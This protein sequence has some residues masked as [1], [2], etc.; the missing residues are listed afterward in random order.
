MDWLRKLAKIDRRIIFLVVF[1]AISIPIFF[2]LNL[3]VFITKEV[4]GV[5]DE[6]DQLPPGSAVMLVFDYEPAATPECDPMATALL[7]HCFSRNLRVIGTTLYTSGSGIAERL[8]TQ[9]GKEYGKVRGKDYVHL[10][11]KSGVFAVVIGLGENLKETFPKDYYGDSTDSLTALHDIHS[12][13]DIPYLVV[14]HDDATVFTWIIYGYER[15][16]IKIGTGCTAVMAPGNYP[17]LQ[18]KQITGI[19]GGLKGA[20]E[21]E[22]LVGYRGSGAAGMD[23]QAVI[24]IFIIALIIFGNI[25]YFVFR[26]EKQKK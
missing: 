9:I 21:Y 11:Y 24:H 10:G 4:R 16:G 17:S 5:Y 23:S 12:L 15:Y 19:I 8:L 7:R 18:A 20:S 25:S 26:R 3:P 1:I 13:K 6:I 22:K 14:L 2:P